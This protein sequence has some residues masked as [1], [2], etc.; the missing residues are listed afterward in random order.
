[1]AWQELF[2]REKK[3]LD[4]FNAETSM[5]KFK[6]RIEI[7]CNGDRFDNLTEYDA[8]EDQDYIRRTLTFQDNEFPRLDTL[9]LLTQ[10]H[11]VHD[12]SRPVTQLPNDN[13]ATTERQMLEIAHDFNCVAYSIKYDIKTDFYSHI[14]GD[15]RPGNI[16]HFYPFSR[17]IFH[18]A[19]AE[20]DAAL[21]DRL[22]AEASLAAR[23]RQVF[24][25]S[26]QKRDDANYE[27]HKNK[28]FTR[29]EEAHMQAAAEA[30]AKQMVNEV[31]I[32]FAGTGN[33]ESAGDSESW[34][35]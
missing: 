25:I 23:K 9:D 18:T 5:K 24:T 15:D 17:P 29:I 33:Q 8:K 31:G 3:F 14:L 21:F 32:H 28:F 20:L 34:F 22:E 19:E 6:G 1:M 27:H 2:K 12:D 7:T 10:V 13:H 11:P 30:S 26:K 35:T 16:F 4:A